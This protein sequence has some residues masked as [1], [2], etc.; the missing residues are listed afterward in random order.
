MR[1][2]QIFRSLAFSGLIAVAGFNT[3]VA[4]HGIPNAVAEGSNVYCAGYIQRAPINTTNRLV[5]GQ[6]EQEQFLYTQNSIVYINA[7]ANRGVQP[8][9][10][11]SV[12]RPRG[13]VDTK[14]S[15]KGALG[16]YVQEV[17]MVEVIR[18][19][20][21]VSV[22]VVRMSCDSMLLGDVLQPW[23]DRSVPAYAQRPAF[24]R[25]AD[26]SGKAIGRLFMARDMQEMVTR[27]QIVYIDLGREDNANIGDYLTIFRPL[28]KGNMMDMPP[29][30][31]TARSYGYES[32]EYRGGRFSS[33]AARKKGDE[34]RGTVQTTRDAKRDRPSDIRKVVGEGVILNVRERTATVLITRTAQEIHTGD[35]VEIQ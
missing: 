32:D 29:E 15:N 12:V 9:M 8:G 35:Y 23:Q 18:V 21:E 7:G 3:A 17:G 22:A 24:D 11:Y 25:F 26:P 14:W 10:R 6:E 1:S 34:A 2:K 16:F 13:Q 4:Q 30:S 19:K 27:D 31:V 28:G 5:G 20:R 33:Q